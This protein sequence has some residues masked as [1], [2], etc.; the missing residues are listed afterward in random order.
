M[1]EELVPPPVV[2]TEETVK[3]EFEYT[4]TEYLKDTL[5]P[6]SLDMQERGDSLKNEALLIQEEF[7]IMGIPSLTVPEISS[8]LIETLTYNW[9]TCTKTD[10]ESCW[11]DLTRYI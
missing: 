4:M 2:R 11:E 7:G 3:E 5:N 9:V 1:S 8:P 6:D 10:A